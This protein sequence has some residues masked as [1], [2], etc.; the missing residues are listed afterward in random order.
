[1]CIHTRVGTGQYFR[2]GWVSFGAVLLACGAPALLAAINVDGHVVDENEAPVSAARVTVHRALP[3]GAWQARTDPDGVFHLTLPDAGDYLITVEREGYYEL[4]DRAV[5]I[6]PA[7]ELSLT[8]NPVRE[9]FQSVNVNEKPSPL[10][11]TRTQNEERLTGT[12]V[13]DVPFPNNHSLLSSFALLPGTVLD[14]TGTPHFDGSSQGQIL[15]TLNGFDITDPIYGGYNAV[16]AVEGVRSVDFSSGRYSPEYGKGSAGFLNISTENGTDAFHY[17]ATD[18]IPGLNIQ[19]GTRLGNW[20]PR[21]GF[22]GP[23]VRGR[24]WFS[25]MFDSELTSSYINGLPSG[26][27]T[28]N[29]WEGSNL[30][31]GQVNLTPSN[32]LF[33]DF[34]VN[35]DNENRVGLGVL[36]PVSTT[37]TVHTRRYFGSLKDQLYLG[38]GTLLEI[39]FARYDSTTKQSPQGSG[40]YVFSPT[41]RSGNYFVDSVQTGTRDEGLLHAWL[42]HFRWLGT[43]QIETGTDVDHNGD[44]AAFRRTGYELEGL[45]DRILSRTM[46]GG[47]GTF[48]VPDTEVGWWVLD[49]WRLSKQLQIEAGLREDWDQRISAFGTSPH[50]S[51]SWAP[52]K[53]GRTRVI[54]GYSITHDPVLLNLLGLPFDQTAVTTAYTSQG[55]PVGALAQSTFILPAGPLKLPRASNWTAGVDHQIGG[56]VFLNAKYLRRRTTDGFVF[57]NELDPDA[58]PSILPLPNA[59]LP[60]EYQL[61]NRR[62]DDYDSVQLSIRQTFSGQFEWMLSYTRSQALSNAVLDY[63]ANQPLQVLPNL[64]PMPWDTPNRVLGWGYLPLPWKNWAVAVLA[65]ARSGFP[66]SA[67]DEYGVVVGEVDAHRYPFNFDLDFAIERMVTLRGY[68]FALRLGV[69]NLTNQANPTAVD[70]TVGSPNYLQF[71]GEEGRHFVVRVRFFGRAE[72]H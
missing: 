5:H 45:N 53:S 30:L 55:T 4:R 62:H 10:D 64:V 14:P 19:N 31:H 50:I 2:C 69:D 25:D 58:A 67:A 22:S 15:Y 52:F 47:Q 59:S 32:I 41:G 70:Y 11:L 49:T 51:A 9:V 40:L 48:H 23:I 12:E 7:Q 6:E 56:R 72:K 39:G 71:Y 68:R 28:R 17:T 27:N 24:A 37:S 13:N 16:L 8:I 43:H 46:F 38:R 61:T 1:M 57:V 44:D 63:N 29:G 3:A 54:A 26:E 20:Y 18:F 42:P 66:F 65:D 34:L 60:G 36:N 35:V 21:V 33:A